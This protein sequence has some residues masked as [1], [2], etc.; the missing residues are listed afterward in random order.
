[1]GGIANSSTATPTSEF[2]ATG[3][4]SAA[5]AR[6]DVLY[7]AHRVPYPPDKGDRI[8]TYHVLRSLS[9]VA[10]VHLACFT[11]EP[12]SPA[13][14]DELG[15]LCRRVEVIRLGNLTWRV[16]AL[17]SLAL[18]GTATEGAF[19]SPAMRDLVARWSGETRFRSA[20]ASSSGMAPYLKDLE[21]RSTPAVVD[22]V[23]V[24]SQ[25]WAEYAETGRGPKAW[26]HRLEARRLAE[27]ERST[28]T[29]A[30][31]VT[32]VSEAEAALFRS[33][34][35]SGPI[36][37]ITN[38]VDLEK[39]H[40]GFPTANPPEGC[41]FI[42]ALDYRPNVDA[43][44]WFCREVWPKVLARRPGSRFAM[45][46]RKPSAAVRQLAELPGVDLVGQVPDVRPY[47]AS[48]AVAVMP[49]RIARGVQ[50][51]V[52]EALAMAKA[53]VASPGA[54]EGI[55]AEPG[56]HLLAASSPEQW[57]E[58]VV[59][60]LDD[61]PFGRSLG[62]AG[63]AFVEGSHDWGRCLTPF[64]ELLGLDHAAEGAG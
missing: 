23:D 39:F 20:I 32:L 36:R 51:K 61:R 52:L 60:L 54:I 24:D 3:D 46:G 16:R 49:L 17:R 21:S 10:N 1:M 13:D 7:L 14:L 63:R 25:K 59:Q 35:G 6:L 34:G 43:V 30:R 64:R 29:W 19:E 44:L 53:V 9:E 31:A 28:T 2:A 37:A 11:D 22:F 27:L 45:V 38:G 8:R 55:Q 57:G 33:A 48:A 26:L 5:G 18:G 15:R 42:G 47:L 40:P 4:P 56:V 41:V 50:N 12:T 62:A 58:A